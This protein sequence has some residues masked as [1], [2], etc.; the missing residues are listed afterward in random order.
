MSDKKE[1]LARYGSEKHIDDIIADKT[2]HEKELVLKNPMVNAGHHEKLFR[3]DGPIHQKS[4][5]A[6]SKNLPQNLRHEIMTHPNVNVRNNFANRA[7]ISDAEF[8]HMKHDSSSVV[9]RGLVDEYSRPPNADVDSRI[10]DIIHNGPEIARNTI[11]GIHDLQ[12]HHV[13]DI[14][15]SDHIPAITEVAQHNI[16]LNPDHIKTLS[17]HPDFRVRGRL[18]MNREIPDYVLSKLSTDE[19]DTVS[20]LAKAEQSRRNRWGR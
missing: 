5:V 13:Y 1:F 9:I 8:Q 10:S 7:D 11:A 15:K 19:H 17:E 20:H 12:S 4:E 3:M 16:N 2:F 18:T 6:R 14:L